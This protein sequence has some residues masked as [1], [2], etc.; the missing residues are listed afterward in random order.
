MQRV[1]TRSWQ[2]I[3][4][5][6]TYF[7]QF[8]RET[9]FDISDSDQWNALRAEDVMAK[10]VGMRL[11]ILQ[12]PKALSVGRR[13]VLAIWRIAPQSSHAYIPRDQLFLCRPFDKAQAR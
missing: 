2:D 4:N 1:T 12:T 6:R 10:K 3:R 8:A 11:L 5:R 7:Q 13:T 9:G